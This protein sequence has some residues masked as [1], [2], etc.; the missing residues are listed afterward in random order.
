MVKKEKTKRN[1]S[2]YPAL[3]PTLNLKTRYE[4]LDY[5]YVNKLSEKDKAWLNK[6]T[7]EYVNDS[8][9]REDL[10]KNLHNTPKLKKDCDDR[11]NARNRDIL[12]RR[13]AAGDM[14]YLEDLKGDESKIC[15]PEEQILMNESSEKKSKS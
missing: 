2:K 14:N 7:D 13:K 6:F 10:S 12:T 8:L 15:T 4:L 1:K 9:N 11:N 5:D 3:D